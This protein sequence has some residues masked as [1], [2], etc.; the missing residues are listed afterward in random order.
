M[1]ATS[2]NFRFLIFKPFPFSIRIQPEEAAEPSDSDLPKCDSTYSIDIPRSE[3]IWEAEPRPPNTGEV[4]FSIPN[5]RHW[6]ICNKILFSF[7]LFQLQYYQFTL[8]AMSLNE[9]PDFKPPNRLCPTDSRLRPD[10]RKLETGDI[11]GAAL[12][13]TRLEEKQR[14]SRK[15]LKSKKEEWKPK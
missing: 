14:D 12:E 1:R 10:V 15:A 8:F 6:T 2:N 5:G 11:D 7:Y 9:M 4:G 3:A 13:K